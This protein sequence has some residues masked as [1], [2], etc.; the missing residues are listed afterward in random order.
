MSSDH[1]P[2]F[3]LVAIASL[4]CAALATRTPVR[5]EERVPAPLRATHPMDALTP[6][7]I[8]ASARILRA[9]GKLGETVRLV[10]LTLEENPQ[11]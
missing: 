3:R 1:G 8:M 2:L 7:E 11:D 10:S 5:A 4:S 9:A 6:D